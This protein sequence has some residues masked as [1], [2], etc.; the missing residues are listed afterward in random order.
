MKTIHASILTLAL[1]ALLGCASAGVKIDRSAT[2]NIR[3][4]VTTKAQVIALLGAPSSD[5]LTGDGR[6]MMIWSYA[7][8]RVKGTTFIPVAG[9]FVGGSN[10]RLTTFQVILTK[11]K[12]VE[13][14]LWNSSNLESRMGR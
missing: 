4:G 11:G 7:H 5:S 3:K 10:T 1:L 9:I 2:E 14:F 8:T 12:I 13:D 6:E